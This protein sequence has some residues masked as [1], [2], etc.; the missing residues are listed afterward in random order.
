MHGLN[1]RDSKEELR[2]QPN[3]TRIAFIFRWLSC[4]KM[5]RTNPCDPPSRRFSA[6]EKSVFDQ[7]DSGYPLTRDKW[8]QHLGYNDQE[9]TFIRNKIY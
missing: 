1:L 4:S 7:L 2:N 3:R 6:F 9:L 5:H 8:Y